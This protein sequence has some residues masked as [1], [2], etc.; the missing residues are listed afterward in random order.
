MSVVIRQLNALVGFLDFATRQL[1]GQLHYHHRLRKRCGHKVS[2][3]PE[4]DAW[5]PLQQ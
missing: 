4:T 5:L 3:Q 1:P 2:V